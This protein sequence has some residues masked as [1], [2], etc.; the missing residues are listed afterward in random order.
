MTAQHFVVKKGG[1]RISK[2]EEGAGSV[3]D[4]PGK[5]GGEKKGKEILRLSPTGKGKKGR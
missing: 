5:R 4:E 1:D 3:M 2:A